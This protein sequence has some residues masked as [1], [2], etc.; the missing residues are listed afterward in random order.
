MDLRTAPDVQTS[1]RGLYE[2]IVRY[3]S[4]NR[5]PG[6]MRR[7][8]DRL[9]FKIALL[10]KDMDRVHASAQA[11]VARLCQDNSVGSYECLL[12]L[13]RIGADLVEHYPQ[14]AAEW[15]R[16]LVEQ[17]VRHTGPSTLGALDK[18]MVYIEA[19]KWFLSGKL[20]L[21][22]LGR[23]GL[24]KETAI[25]SRSA[26]LEAARTARDPGLGDPCE[27]TAT[28]RRYLT[29]LD[30]YPPRGPIDVK[31][32][33]SI[34]EEGLTKYY[35]DDTSSVRRRLVENTL[36]SIHLAVGDGPF[37]G[38]R[39][40]LI[41]SVEHFAGLY[42]TVDK[43]TEPID[44]VLATFLALC[45]CDISTPE[46]HGVL[47]SQFREQCAQVQAQVNAMLRDRALDAFVTTEDVSRAVNLYERIFRRYIDDPLWPAFKF[48]FT[49]SEQARLGSRMK[50]RLMELA[51]FLDD[52]SL[53]LKYGGARP[54]L[55]KKTVF[56]ISRAAQKLLAEAAFLRNPAYPGVSCQYR[57]GYGFT[58]VIRGPLYRESDRP[59][60]KL[61]AMKYFHLGH[62]LESVVEHERE[63]ILR[64]EKEVM[65]K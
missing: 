19:N 12:E 9:R 54:E 48:P 41:E 43:V 7:A 52:M 5:V 55:K 30:A 18:L 11:S 2:N 1:S 58:A 15:L 40:R 14:Q 20:L 53:K 44:T 29:Q 32:V 22:E 64:A 42:L 33:R 51:P 21:A 3:L 17:A 37:C 49:A 27:P 56:E 63:L 25:S 24:M 26:R 8:L 28:V 65:T 31:G 57:G 23:Q 47:F 6:Q 38:D 4:D 39:A 36:R 61:K 50:L 60:E 45:F 34:L 59:R 46:D 10:T 13:A 62:R 35:P 16:P